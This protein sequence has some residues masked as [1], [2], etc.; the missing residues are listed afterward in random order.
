[1]DEISPST[2]GSTNVPPPVGIGTHLKT[3][4]EALRLSEKEVAAR[5]H[6]NARFIDMMEREDFNGVPPMFMRGYLRSYARLVHLDETKVSSAIAQLNLTPPTTAPSVPQAIATT[7][8]AQHHSLDRYLRWSSY[9]IISVLFLLVIV[10]WSSHLSFSEIDGATK[11]VAQNDQPTAPLIAAPANPINNNALNANSNL[12]AAPT[13]NLT[14]QPT[15]AATTNNSDPTQATNPTDTS[16]NNVVA[17]KTKSH[18]SDPIDE[19][20]NEKYIDQNNIY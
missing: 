6:L 14:A 7:H 9:G 17:A 1:M 15:I 16:S 5:L 11:Q 18:S 12:L 13:N 2:Q 10:W 3:A 20:D 4:R 8:E 19:E